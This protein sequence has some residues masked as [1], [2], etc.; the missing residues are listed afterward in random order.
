MIVSAVEVYPQECLGVLMGYRAWNSLDKT[1]RAIVEQAISYQ[2]AERTTSTVEV[3]E[4]HE[5]RCKEL[6]YNISPLEPI[7]YF[8]SHPR[9]DAVLSSRD[10][11]SMELRDIEIIIAI[12]RK[13]MSKPWGYSNKDEL[14]GVFGDFRFSLAAYSCFKDGRR[15][16][17]FERIDLLCPSALGIGS[18]HY[19]VNMPFPE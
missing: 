5:L 11:K 15:P 9:T 1:R 4:R 10:K 14:T 2:T 3:G 17:N 19:N 6:L 13:T 18:K 8:H 7:G 16:R 12:S